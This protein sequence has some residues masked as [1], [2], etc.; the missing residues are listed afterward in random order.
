[1]SKIRRL[2]PDDIPDLMRLSCSAGWNQVAGDWA[3]LLALE[4][5]GCF[6]IEADGRIVA[7]A[8]AICYGHRLA[9]IGMVLTDPAW[10]RRGLARRLMEH[11][12]AFTERRRIE[13]VKL[14][15][16]E[17]GRPLYARLG[18]HDE[19]LV[20]RWASAGGRR[21]VPAWSGGVDPGAVVRPWSAREAAGWRTMDHRA[22]G[23]GRGRLLERLARHEAAFIAGAGFAL[24][25]PGAAAFT[26]GPCV[27]LTP[28]TA[29]SL[30]AW[31]LRSHPRDTIYWD[32]LPE[33]AEAVRLAR[34]FGFEMKRRLVRMVGAGAAR[35]APVRGDPRLVYATAGFEYG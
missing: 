17:M 28:K 14:D 10:R 34:E 22:F 13:W 4:P 26:F 5:E 35:A 3:R 8:T 15:A 23:A 32:L 1:M 2:R 25:R 19:C 7:T 21:K 27:A 16:T 29:R 18:F 11:S 33:N 6:G 12:L 30:L 24:I 9:W 31:S 20:E